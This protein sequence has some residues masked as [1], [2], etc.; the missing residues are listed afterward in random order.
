MKGE[1]ALAE[2]AFKS[3]VLNLSCL[4]RKKKS[5]ALSSNYS[6]MINRLKIPEGIS[7]SIIYHLLLDN[8]KIRPGQLS[9]HTSQQNNPNIRFLTSSSLTKRIKIKVT[10]VE[11]FIFLTTKDIKADLLIWMDFFDYFSNKLKHAINIYS[12]QNLTIQ[13]YNIINRGYKLKDFLK[14][15]NYEYGILNLNLKNYLK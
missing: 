11:R 10:Q 5:L 9:I 13:K 14:R 2:K 3:V 1:I 6:T 15:I 12:I 4:K 8:P 7:L